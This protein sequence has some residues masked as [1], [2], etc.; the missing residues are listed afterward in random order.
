MD[1]KQ[2]TQQA[3]LRFSAQIN[4]LPLTHVDIFDTLL[5][6]ILVDSTKT[7]G[8]AMMA[9]I[10]DLYRE[11]DN[12]RLPAMT[13]SQLLAEAYRL[14]F[15]DHVG[16]HRYGTEGALDHPHIVQL[17]DGLTHALKESAKGNAQQYVDTLAADETQRH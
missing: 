12:G 2:A 15:C 9:H 5:N 3:Y 11:M 6:L 8:L 7:T 4:S 13:P 10:R 17:F 16:A 14:T 1:T